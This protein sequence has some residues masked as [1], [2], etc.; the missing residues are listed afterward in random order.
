MSQDLQTF[1]WNIWTGNESE[2]N[3]AISHLDSKSAYQSAE[4]SQHKTNSGWSVRRLAYSDGTGRI[5]AAAQCLFRK[6]PLRTAVVWM[7]GGPSGDFKAIDHAFVSVLKQHLQVSFIYLRLGITNAHDESRSN[8]LSA[9][10]WKSCSESIGAQSSLVIDLSSPD[11]LRF[12][13]MSSDWKRNLKRSSKHDLTC[14]HWQNP[15]A[16][17][18]ADAIQQM[19]QL[20]E[21]GLAKLRNSVTE[22]QSLID[23]FGKQLL[24]VRC[25]SPSG[26]LLSIRGVLVTDNQARELFAA[27]TLEGRDCQ[28]SY[29]SFEFL[30][31]V[32]KQINVQHFDLGGV[33]EL[34]NPGVFSFKMGTGAKPIT[35]LGDWEISQPTWF[36]WVAS[37]IVISRAN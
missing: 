21:I 17:V 35:Y 14:F 3:S 1:S 8:A 16:Q 24:V 10:G 18:I 6:G 4:W 9:S 36:M 15:D 37:K 12:E 26:V 2:W 27:T 20:K 33:D 25:D 29:A 13:A 5:K 31:S 7:P 11:E 30:L 23:L 19:G 28:A 32:L 22:L 34:N